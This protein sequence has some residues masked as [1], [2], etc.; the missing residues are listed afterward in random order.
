MSW[1]IRLNAHTKKCMIHEHWIP[2]GKPLQSPSERQNKD[3]YHF[4]GY[5]DATATTSTS[6]SKR[7]ESWMGNVWT[8]SRLPVYG[9]HLVLFLEGRTHVFPKWTTYFTKKPLVSPMFP[10]FHRCSSYFTACSSY[11]TA[12]SPYFAAC[13][14]YFTCCSS[15]F[16]SAAA[17]P[18]RKYRWCFL[19]LV[20]WSHISILYCKPLFSKRVHSRETEKTGTSFGVAMVKCIKSTTI[21]T[22]HDQIERCTF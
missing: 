16:M 6:M 14:S 22:W 17:G 4:C 18:F 2:P 11:F 3:G 20:F 10:L 8:G 12:C 9:D 19:P 13:S 15:S 21:V 5:D 1:N 7:M